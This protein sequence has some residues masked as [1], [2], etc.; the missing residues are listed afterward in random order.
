MVQIPRNERASV[1]FD[2]A[3]EEPGRQV[4]LPARN[5]STSGILLGA[6]ELPDLGSAV[7]LVLSLPSNGVFLRIAGLVVRHGKGGD[8]TFAVAFS[9]LDERTRGEIAD[10]VRDARSA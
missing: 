2:V 1:Q 10:F 4:F 8:P 3:C 7:Q 6:E 9:N 5:L